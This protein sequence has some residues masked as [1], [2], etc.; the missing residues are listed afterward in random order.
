LSCL[1]QLSFPKQQNLP[2]FDLFWY[3]GGM[4]PFIPEELKEDNRDIPEEGMMFVGDKGKI[5]AGFR[6]NQPEIIPS[7]LMEAY[8]GEK[9]IPEREAGERGTDKRTDTWVAAIKNDEESPG[10]FIHAG[11]VT[12]TI[13]L[14]AVALRAKI[15]VDYDSANMKITND[16]AANKYLTREYRTGWEL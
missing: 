13:N 4:K 12:E 1:I 8:Q 14:V 9:E 15:K 7:R 2:A 3:D 6:G 11:T 16:E 5:L 10:S